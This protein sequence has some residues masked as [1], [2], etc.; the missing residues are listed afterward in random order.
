MNQESSYSSFRFHPSE[1]PPAGRWHEGRRRPPPPASGPI[2]LETS[3]KGIESCSAR[4]PHGWCHWWWEHWCLS[5]RHGDRPAMP[6]CRRP[7]RGPAIRSLPQGLFRWAGRRTTA[8]LGQARRRSQRRHLRHPRGPVCWP[9]CSIATCHRPPHHP[10]PSLFTCPPIPR[11]NRTARSL[12]F[13]GWSIEPLPHPPLTHPRPQPRAA[14]ILHR[15]RRSPCCDRWLCRRLS[16][17][18]LRHH[19]RPHRH[20]GSCHCRRWPCY[21]RRLLFRLLAQPPA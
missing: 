19:Q 15:R 16:L 3:C 9:A 10:S 21:N 5:P 1:V 12:G 20:R 4:Q 13:E 11:D 7:S 17:R 6:H 14:A 8:P 18:H 2:V